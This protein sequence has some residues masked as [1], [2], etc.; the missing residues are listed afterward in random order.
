MFRFN[1]TRA[2]YLDDTVEDITVV[3]EN[4]LWN[5]RFW[6]PRRQEIEIR[7]RTAWLDLPV[8]GIIRG[9][10]EIDGYEFNLGLADSVFFGPEI[11]AVPEA[12]RDSFVWEVPFDDAVREASGPIESFDLD[13]VRGEIAAMAG[14][15]AMSGLAR[16]RPRVGSVSDLARFNRVEGLALGFGWVFRPGGTWEIDVGVSYGFSDQDFKGRLET[17][18][19]TGRV[20]FSAKL[21]RWVDDVSDELVV[22]P[23]LNSVL[24]QERGQDYGDYFMAN[25][26]LGSVEWSI[27]SRRYLLV[28]GGVEPLP[29]SSGPAATSGS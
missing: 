3:L 27:N 19:R 5:Q 21:E 26:G 22:S 7:R 1:F 14:A 24:A 2:S 9:H 28:T 17:R 29:T 25:R 6:L 4:G 18:Y 23:I 16:T 13:E 15:Q 10:W 8:R 12:V 20:L 11:V